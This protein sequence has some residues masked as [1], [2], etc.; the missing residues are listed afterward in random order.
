MSATQIDSIVIVGGG[1]AGWMAAAALA[2]FSRRRPRSIT[3][4]ESSD[5]GTV[6]VGEATLPTLRNFNGSLGLDEIDFLKKTQAT[7]KLGIEFVNWHRRGE[8]FFHPFAP[9]GVRFNSASFHHAW[10]RSRL[11]GDPTPLG[12]YSLPAAM[13]A[14]GRFAQ[15]VR[16]PLHAFANFAYAYHFDAGLYARY[17]RD[18]AV[19]LGVNH[20][21]RRIID[22]AL[23]SDDG[24][25]D[26]VVLESGERIAAQLFV[27]CSG[28]R[29]LLIEGALKTGY[30]EWSQWLP[31]DRA[32]AMPSE[33]AGEPLPYTRAT[34]L[35]AGWQWR[36]P[37]QHRQGNGYV[38]CSRFLSDDA[39]V[40]TLRARLEGAPL[41]E[42][43]PL[44]FTTGRRRL[45]WN[46]NCVSLGLAS[47][48]I[49]PLESTSIA[50]IQSGIAKLLTF[51]PD[52]GFSRVDTDEANRLMQEEYER[53][54]DFIILHYKGTARDDAPLWRECRD[55]PIPDTLS[56]KIDLF[57][58]RGHVVSY[59]EESF[60]EASWVTMFAGF[61]LLPDRYDSRVDVLDHAL[62]AEQ[63]LELRIAIRR[64]A[65]LATVHREFIARH[66][67]ALSH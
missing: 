52:R 53:I 55:M 45:F 54:R 21:D 26:A 18:Y 15:P 51:F 4:I 66:C 47:G 25:I 43:N 61:D 34:A 49:E 67:A 11:A 20:V 16:Q 50:L 12:D 30:E 19:A 46:R 36:I 7:F 60:E 22:V 24:A 64:G 63:L 5:V 28:F 59:A 40:A 9:Y 8:K 42:P 58:S 14:L 6:G 23:K 31:C 3:L 27:D 57:R 1:T 62:L 35:E 10:L 39:A 38:Y 56:R 44:R 48:F 32:V 37:L 2:N 33:N 13:S 17:L 29:G 65:E 41:A